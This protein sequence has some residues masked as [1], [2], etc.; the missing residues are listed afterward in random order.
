MESPGLVGPVYEVGCCADPWETVWWD[1]DKSEG[2][3]VNLG[4]GRGPGA[5]S[6]P[7][8]IL[9]SVSA[10]YAKV[11]NPVSLAAEILGGGGGRVVISEEC[12]I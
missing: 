2:G 3:S 9:R 4:R 12:Y 10:R 1:G 7:A 6:L 8:A 5:E 11:R